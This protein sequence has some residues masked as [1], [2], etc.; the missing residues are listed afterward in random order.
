MLRFNVYKNPACGCCGGC[1]IRPGNTSCSSGIDSRRNAME[2]P[3]FIRRCVIAASATLFVSAAYPQAATAERMEAG[4]GVG[5]PGY[6]GAQ[7]AQGVPG[8]SAANAGRGADVMRELIS[9]ALKG[10]PEIR[11][12]LNEREAA[13]Q[14]VA[15]AG[16]LEDPMLEAG[17]LN[18]P[19]DSLRLNRE[20]MTMK[21]LGL[22]QKLPWPGKRAL[23]QK[24]AAKD[25]EA[26]EHGFRETVNRVGRDVKLA[27]LDLSLVA[28]T[29]RL[30]QGNRQV[31]EQFLRIAESRYSLGQGTQAEVLKAQT[32]L[33]K[34]SDELLR[35]ERERP[36]IEAE[37]SRLLGR[38]GVDAQF[39]AELP[40]LREGEL[41]FDSLREAALRQR[42]Q[43][44]A[45]RS[46]V[47][48]G[49]SALE[50][51]R[52]ESSPDL[53]VRL[54]YGQRDNTLDGMR[55]SDMVSF[56]VAINLPVWGKDKT[57]SRIAEAQAM[58]EQAMSLYEAQQNEVSAKLR[59]QVAIAEQSRKS[60]RLYETAILPQA[61]LAV[62]SALSAY[63]V[64]R[65]DLLTL[66]DSQM[67]LYGYRI[68][69]ATALVN[70]NKALAEIGLLT[71]TV[72]DRAGIEG[73]NK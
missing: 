49:N 63:R 67:S 25:A 70:F 28:E 17:L 13:R 8:E 2:I 24:V 16:A 53:D 35:M 44:L 34:M 10:N 50:L 57:D 19:A 33:A 9:E 6:F 29:I 11:A 12:A 1:S 27:Y 14:R 30:M 55:R 61:G 32:Q 60:A 52:K 68:S 21:M 72:D 40:A 36:A 73:D 7:I 15:P 47:D 59:A 66:L 39:V 64:S 58:R 42:P 23:R 62:E 69:H 46:I 22:S 54:S 43:L 5:K 51:A 38:A 4:A 37:L 20:D 3:M 31:L 45:L 65:A 56:T 26:T 48:R 18:V 71:G 41:S